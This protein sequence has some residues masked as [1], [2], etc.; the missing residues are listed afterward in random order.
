M[1]VVGQE[2]VAPER[3]RRATEAAQDSANL[4]K[5]DSS[6][7]WKR[8]KSLLASQKRGIPKRLFDNK[9]NL[10]SGPAIMGEIERAVKA[11]LTASDEHLLGPTDSSFDEAVAVRH[12]ELRTAAG[13]MQDWQPTEDDVDAVLSY[14]CKAYRK[15][16]SPGFKQLTADMVVL[17][18]VQ[19]RE[20]IKLTLRMLATCGRTPD[21]WGTIILIMALKPGRPAQNVENSYRP[22][23]LGELLMKGCESALKIHYHTA[24]I[25]KPLHPSIMA[26]RKGIGTDIGL[27]TLVRAALVAKEQKNKL[28]LVAIDIKCAFNGVWKQLLE[29]L[30]WDMHGI[31]GAIWKLVK[32]LSS[33]IHVQFLFTIYNSSIESSTPAQNAPDI[34]WLQQVCECYFDGL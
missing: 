17:G 30:E 31:T 9:I 16:T 10:L 22:I 2:M 28:F 27:Y 32:S 15:H 5:R 3:R 19:M 26:Y 6:Q 20:A 34:S 11:M 14:F 25:T 33:C 24:L 23:S 29:V 7:L 13:K 1:R 18:H 12:A 8:R 4:Q 21:H